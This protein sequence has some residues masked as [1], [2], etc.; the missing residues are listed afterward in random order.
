MEVLQF[1]RVEIEKHDVSAMLV[2]AF[3]RIMTKI[4]THIMH[5][6]YF[7]LTFSNVVVVESL[8]TALVCCFLLIM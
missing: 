6:E 2:I 8:N 5:I 1:T 7:F 3:I 4:E